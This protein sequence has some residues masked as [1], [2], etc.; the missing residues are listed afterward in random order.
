MALVFP[1]EKFS[2][3]QIKT[4][5]GG[6]DMEFRTLRTGSAA[7]IHLEPDAPFL[8]GKVARHT[9]YLGVCTDMFAPVKDKCAIAVHSFF[10]L[11]NRVRAAFIFFR[12]SAILTALCL[13]EEAPIIRSPSIGL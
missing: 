3:R 13:C 6:A 2:S 1:R 10:L 9:Q 7:R 5:G 4:V 12:S 8:L 11:R